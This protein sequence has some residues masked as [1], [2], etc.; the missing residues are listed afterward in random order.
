VFLPAR[1]VA[2]VYSGRMIALLVAGF[3]PLTACTGSK[4]DEEIHGRD[5]GPDTASLGDTSSIRSTPDLLANAEWT[6]AYG[7]VWA[8]VVVQSE[9]GILVLDA[10]L[11]ADL[12]YAEEDFQ[13]T[14][15]LAETAGV[16][17]LMADDGE[18]LWE[19]W[20]C[21]DTASSHAGTE[22]LSVSGTVE[23]TAEFLY[24]KEHNECTYPHDNV[25]YLAT[26]V[27]ADVVFEDATGERVGPI[28]LP[29]FTTTI[30]QNVCGG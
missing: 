28:S 24:A 3:T 1:A 17:V 6:R 9:H 2:E 11:D 29:T 30:G 10:E 26:A 4:L 12:R 23:L 27:V 20:D 18:T 7:C 15:P 8:Y 14:L 25:H 21:N 13:E 22:W 5:A 19:V 16:S